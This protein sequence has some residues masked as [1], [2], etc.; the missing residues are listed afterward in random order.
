M[1][2]CSVANGHD[3]VSQGMPS[4]QRVIKQTRRTTRV[5]Q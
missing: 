5:L 2:E 4:E 3:E 1:D